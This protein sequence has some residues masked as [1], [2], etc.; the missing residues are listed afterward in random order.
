MNALNHGLDAE[1]LILPGESEA[2]YRDRLE[3]WTGAKP[4]RDLGPVER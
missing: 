1:T 4:P 2:E 3:A